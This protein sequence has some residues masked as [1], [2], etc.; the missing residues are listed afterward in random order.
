MA[1]LNTEPEGMYPEYK[2]DI[3][4]AF[5]RIMKSGE[6]FRFTSESGMGKSKYLRYISASKT[7]YSRFF[8]KDKIKL[9]YIDLNGVYRRNAEDLILQFNKALGIKESLPDSDRLMAEVFK[10]L[11]EYEKIYFL[12]DQA[13]ILSG[14]SD[15]AIHLLRSWRD[16]YKNKMSYVF[17]FEKGLPIDQMKLRYLLNITYIDI[18]FRA[19]NLEESHACV[20]QEV[21]KMGINISNDEKLKIIELAN[22]V[23]REIK[24]LVSDLFS[25]KELRA[26][27]IQDKPIE[28]P[29]FPQQEDLLEVAQ[30]SL[31]KN[32]Y[33]FFS[34]LCSMKDNRVLHRD[35]IAN[36]ISP[37]S[38]GAGVSNEA[39]DQLVSRTRK[40][41]SLINPDIEIKTKRG[42]GYYI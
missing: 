4:E 18:Y 38:S 34:K 30:R 32:E 40:A 24:R 2:S 26:L 35:E 17:S 33:L 20:M 11:E 37:E 31:T 14:F 1:T 39:I 8:S 6:S 41:L 10:V 28:T 25:G 3:T 29:N 12:V 7:I 19:L 16:T 5:V 23:P 15:E 42:L 13:E 22:G 27:E 9:V 36:I 21:A